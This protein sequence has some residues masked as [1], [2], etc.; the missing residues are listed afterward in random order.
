MGHTPEKS[1]GK[2]TLNGDGESE[3]PAVL[4]SWRGAATLAAFVRERGFLMHDRFVEFSAPIAAKPLEAWSAELDRYANVFVSAGRDSVDVRAMD[5]AHLPVWRE[6]IMNRKKEFAAFHDD[7]F[8]QE[9]KRHPDWE[10]AWSEKPVYLRTVAGRIAEAHGCKPT[11]KGYELDL[12]FGLLLEVEIDIGRPGA[13]HQRLAT[14]NWVH[15]RVT[16]WR[17]PLP[18]VALLRGFELYDSART[19]AEFVWSI[20]AYVTACLGFKASLR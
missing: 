9:T 15:S 20:E 1:M 3:R 8:A 12:G 19:P 11:K 4:R 5:A 14:M 7:C 18:W 2:P 16:K 10:S 17:A 13:T 6:L